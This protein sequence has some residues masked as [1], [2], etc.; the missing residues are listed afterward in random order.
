L[1]LQH[2]RRDQIWFCERQGL[3]STL[4]SL[5]EFS[6]RKD[7][8]FEVGYLRGKYGAVPQAV[9]DPMWITAI[10]NF[11]TDDESPDAK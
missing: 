9:V 2:L 11:D 6:P 3:D 7:E 5:L 1:N 8:N 10:N 4:Y